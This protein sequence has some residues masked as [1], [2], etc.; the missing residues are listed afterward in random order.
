MSEFSGFVSSTAAKDS[1]ISRTRSTNQSLSRLIPFYLIGSVVKCLDVVLIVAASVLTGIAYHLVCWGSYGPVEIFLGIGALIAVNCS[2]MLSASG[3]YR[4]HHL[5]DVRLQMRDVSAVWVFAFFLL[6][7]LAFSLKISETY[8]RGA[9]LSFFIFGWLTIL[10]WR[11]IASQFIATA[12]AEGGFAEQK[13][14][15]LAE[16]GQ[17]TESSI[18]DELNRYGYKPARTYQFSRDLLSSAAGNAQF[19]N[20]VD[21]ILISSR[22]E[23]IECVFLMVPWSDRVTVDRLMDLLSVLTVPVHLLP[24]RNVAYFLGNRIVNIGNAWV[25]ELK[26]APLTATERIFKR[27]FD[28]SIATFVLAML[29]PMMALI[30]FLIKLESP[31]PILFMQTRNGFNGRPFRIYKFRTMSVVEDGPIIRQATKNDPR[32]TRLGRLLRR[33]NIDELPQLL[34]VIIGNMSLVGPRPHAAAHNLEYEKI[35]AKYAYR[36]HVK[37]GLT[38]WAQINGFRGETRTLDLMAKRV[39]FDLWYVNNWSHW[40]DFKI[41]VRTLF[42][43]IQAGAY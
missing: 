21:D 43:G 38:G 19:S 39:E 14:I 1:A 37:P 30:A 24:D 34:N 33:T 42:I 27:L 20:L 4:P 13:I 36:Y 9:T 35:V 3:T 25:P 17:L 8:S 40:L 29:M 12:I 7:L 5:A 11:L 26:R 18:V 23:T 28:V 10:I 6:S 31:G 16:E 32:V 15:L 22:K 41:L 2:A